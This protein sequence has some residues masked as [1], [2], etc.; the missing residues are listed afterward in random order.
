MSALGSRCP[1]SFDL[2]RA[3]HGQLFAAPAAPSFGAVHTR[4]DDGRPCR[5]GRRH[6]PDDPLLG[7]AVDAET[8]DCERAVMW[9][10]NAPALWNRFM[11]DLVRILAADCDLIESAWRRRVRVAYAKV[12]EFP[13][14]GLV[15][16]HAIILD[17]AE[18]RALGPGDRRF[19]PWRAP[20]P[21]AYGRLR[22]PAIP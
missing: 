21:S 20:S 14:R 10:W 22:G 16:F 2:V 17:S 8:Y 7:G 1:R 19:G 15:H 6:K 3:R 18:D 9:N 11:V 4:R 12:A 5:C 13:A